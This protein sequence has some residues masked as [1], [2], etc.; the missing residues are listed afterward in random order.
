MGDYKG[1]ERAIGPFFPLIR[2]KLSID[3]ENKLIKFI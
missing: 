2:N 3:L 1:E